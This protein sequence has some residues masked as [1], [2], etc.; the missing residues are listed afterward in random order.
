MRRSTGRH[1]GRH[2]VGG[3]EIGGV[4]VGGGE[5]TAAR[6]AAGSATARSD[7]YINVGRHGSVTQ[8][9]E[10]LVKVSTARATKPGDRFKAA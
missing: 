3:G 5:A 1:K 8:L 4:E 9:S 7:R 10:A 2:Q 6:L